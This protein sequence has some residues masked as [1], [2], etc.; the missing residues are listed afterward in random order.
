MTWAKFAQEICGFGTGILRRLAGCGGHFACAETDSNRRVSKTRASPLLKTAR[1]VNARK[2]SNAKRHSSPNGHV[3][4]PR[5]R[6]ELPEI[7]FGCESAEHAYDGAVL[8][9]S[10]RE[11]AKQKHTEQRTIRNG[12]DLQPDFDHAS[13]SMQAEDCQSEQYCCP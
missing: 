5:H 2:V 4:G 7:N 8:I 3:P 9:G 11:D 6:G 1:T 10:A 12:G 13:H